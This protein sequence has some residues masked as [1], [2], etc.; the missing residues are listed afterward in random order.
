MLER[1]N[2]YTLTAKQIVLITYV[3]YYK[4]KLF[5]TFCWNWT[6]RLA[7]VLPNLVAQSE[8]SLKDVFILNV[9][10]DEQNWEMHTR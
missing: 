2:T 8:D 9:K 7:N 4:L 3:R 1:C 5:E 10:F 6:Y